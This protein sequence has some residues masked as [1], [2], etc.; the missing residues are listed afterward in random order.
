[1]QNASKVFLYLLFAAIFTTCQ[2]NN[3]N[4]N[5][6]DQSNNAAKPTNEAVK[7][8]LVE[9][10]LTIK[11]PFHPEEARWME[12]TFGKP[13]DN[14]VPGPT[15]KKLTAVLLFQKPDADKIV[16]QAATYGTPVPAVINPEKWYPNE[17]V[18]Q[19][20]TSGDETLKGNS[21]PAN[22]FLNLP[23]TDG[24]ITRIEGTDYFVLELYAK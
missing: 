5:A 18:A 1:M 6:A 21:Y 13:G 10:E 22:D 9:L 17:L 3:G 16:E 11:L 2:S 7:D 12:E 19:S 20:Q 23:Y 14:R 24:K 8:D 15:D 4:L